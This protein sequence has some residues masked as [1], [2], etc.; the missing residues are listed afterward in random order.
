MQGGLVLKPQERIE[1]ALEELSE[2]LKSRPDK[3][4][5]LIEEDLMEGC[6]PRYAPLSISR[7]PDP[8]HDLRQG[9]PPP[10][11]TP[12]ERLAGA[13]EGI[14]GPLKME[15]PIFPCV[16]IGSGGVGFI[17]TVFGI[18]LDEDNPAAP[19]TA[20]NNIPLADFR[21]REPPDVET[22][23][24]MPEILEYLDTVKENTPGW[25]QINLP[26][27]QG[28]F[29]IAQ[30]IVGTDLFMDM[31]DDPDAYGILMQQITD[32]WIAAHR[33]LTER[34]GADRLAKAPWRSTRVAECSVNL[35]SAQRYQASV[36]PYDLQIAEHFGN[37]VAIH[38]CSG[39][40][41]IKTTLDLLPNVLS[42]EAG[43]IPSAT[44]GS[45]GMDEILGLL[46]DRQVVLCYGEELVEGEEE[47][48]I[49]GYMERLG[50]YPTIQFGFTGMYWKKA[51]EPM[52]VEL[53]KKLDRWYAEEFLPTVA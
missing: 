12:L 33:L 15:N 41:V 49:R 42:T 24:K 10:P 46:K 45:M 3:N 37:C 39:P 11:P 30:Q 25:I 40:H 4:L 44:A 27:F 34:I 2:V 47:T 6:I 23:G 9:P 43:I 35:I 20:L 28:P 8:E 5:L 31:E 13:M 53:H 7:A 19:T 36:L 26:D 38:P 16:G 1:R 21:D 17:P 48:T 50:E 51:D 29:N 14:P 18:E 32:F 22:S 52:I